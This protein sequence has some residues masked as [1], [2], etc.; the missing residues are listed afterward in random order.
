[1]PL[2]GI[3][4]FSYIFRNTVD[5]PIHEAVE[6]CFDNSSYIIRNLRISVAPIS[7]GWR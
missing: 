2:R 7:H 4:S 1:M 3:V 6:V 5:K